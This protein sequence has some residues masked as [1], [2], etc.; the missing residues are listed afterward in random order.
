MKKIKRFLLLNDWLW[1]PLLAFIFFILTGLGIQYIFKTEDGS[2]AGFYDASFWQ[3]AVYAVGVV[4]M[5]SGA[6]MVGM[7]V[8][9]KGYWRYIYSKDST[10]RDD[11]KKLQPWQKFL[12]THF[13]FY[14]FILVM[15]IV[16]SLLV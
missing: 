3:A 2:A 1:S 7:L 11:F 14:F 16:F 15:L 13:S 5:F 10:I 12:I 8:N 4:V 9:F 6:G